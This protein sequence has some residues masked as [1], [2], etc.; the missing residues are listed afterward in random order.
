VLEIVI[1]QQ[2]AGLFSSGIEV[3]QTTAIRSN[4]VNQTPTKPGGDGD[5][6]SRDKGAEE[7]VMRKWNSEQGMSLVEATII[8]M[9]LA[10]L[11]GVIA[12][13]AS[14]YVAD[15]RM[16]K[17]KEDVEAIGIGIAR[18]LRDTGSAC[19][20]EAGG[21]VCTKANREDLLH[22]NTGNQPKASTGTCFTYARAADAVNTTGCWLPEV[23]TAAAQRGTIEEHLI[24]NTPDYS[25]VVFNTSPLGSRGWRGA[26]MPD[27][28]PDPWGYMY[29]ANT[30]FLAVATD[31]SNDALEGGI[32]GG[33]HKDVIVLSPGPDGVVHTAFGSN[34]QNPSGDDVIYVIKGA[35][36]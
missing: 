9:V 35:T 2:L 23:D 10:I 26:Y 13:S 27:S 24:N 31:A 14:D 34:G 21:T 11:T 6:A 7:I 15:A 36:R 17:A 33:W 19:L 28:G 32:T 16:T 29:Q 3:A 12:P 4:P 30:V 5:S 1:K 8:L 18:L 20:R 25:D 22:G